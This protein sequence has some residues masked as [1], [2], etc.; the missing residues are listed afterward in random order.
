M[1]VVGWH[2]LVAV[3]W[4]SLYLV[5]LGAVVDVLD[6]DVVVVDEVVVVVIVVDDNIKNMQKV[7]QERT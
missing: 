2:R 7:T 1:Q 6:L 4:R 5:V 3:V